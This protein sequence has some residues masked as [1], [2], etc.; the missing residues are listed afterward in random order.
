MGGMWQDSDTVPSGKM[1]D[2]KR[3]AACATAL[4]LFLKS[5]TSMN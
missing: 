4:E 2:K 5:E 1:A 3:A